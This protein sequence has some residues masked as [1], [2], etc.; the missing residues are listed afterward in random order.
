[1]DGDPTA[2]FPTPTNPTNS[3]TYRYENTQEAA[4][5]WYHDHAQGITG[6][7]VYAGLASGYLIRNPDDDGSGSKLP[8]P[9]FEQPLIIQDRSFTSQCA[10]FYPPNQNPGTFGQPWA[11]ESFGDV[12]TVNGKIWPN[13]NVTPGKYRFRV[14]NGSNAR[15]YNFALK[16]SKKGPQT[17]FQI[18]SDGGL[19]NAPFPLTSLLLTPGE[20]AD[21]VVDFAGLPVGTTVI[22][23]NDAAA[24]FPIG[25]TSVKR[26]GMPLP[27]IMQFSVVAGTAFTKP[28]PVT[29]RTNPIKP[30]AGQ[31]LAA[32]R[33]MDLV[34][35]HNALGSPLMVLLNNRNFDLRDP[36]TNARTE[37]R[38]KTDALEQWEIINTTVDAHPIH[39][40]FTQFQVLNRQKFNATSYL[41]AAYPGQVPLAPNTGP[42]PPPTVT[43]FLNGGPK[44]PPPTN[45]GGRTP[46]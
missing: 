32:T 22:L 18:G 8:P 10:F 7:N 25:P 31:P 21:I 1:M 13:L 26:G 20:R 19:L 45:W 4:G 15:V 6:L 17:I 14:Y 41:A 29:L 36:I 12:S 28:L 30:F 33:S 3:F 44:P 5:I 42:Y 34:E 27:Q 2:T 46:S 35:I 38:V 40:H 39:R 23:T 24:P 37:T 9:P 11:P 43:P 16:A